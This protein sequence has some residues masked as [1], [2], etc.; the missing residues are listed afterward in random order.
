VKGKGNY[1]LDE[2]TWPIVRDIFDKSLSGWSLNKIALWLTQHGVPT[3]S[4]VLLQR[5]LR[6]P[7]KKAKVATEWKRQTVAD[8][9]SNPSYTGKHTV[10]RRKQVKMY[11]QEDS[12]EW[13]PVPNDTEPRKTMVLRDEGDTKRV[14]VDI[15]SIISEAEWAQ[16]QAA[17]MRRKEE[18]SRRNHQPEATLLRS[19]IAICGHCGRLMYVASAP[20]KSYT[21]YVCSGKRVAKDAKP[22]TYCPGGSFNLAAPLVDGPVWEAVMEI[23]QHKEK[24]KEILTRRQREEGDKLAEAQREDALTAAQI[25]SLTTQ[26]ANLRENLRLVKGEA[27]VLLAEDLEQVTGVLRQLEKKRNST[28]MRVNVLDAFINHLEET[29]QRW[30]ANGGQVRQDGDTL[31]LSHPDDETDPLHRRLEITLVKEDTLDNITYDEKR[32]LMRTLGIQVKMYASNSDFTR[33]TGRR[34]E[35]VGGPD[36]VSDSSYRYC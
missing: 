31:V 8:I 7:G 4:Q 16:A 18:A 22:G 14:V 30:V 21:E 11:Y 2:E 33:E 24:L 36:I 17:M 12:K 15:P 10:Y 6:N 32:E 23:A 9:V 3:P 25:E 13:T 20:R 29:L 1:L 28:S 34:W 19:G 27:A 26:Q 35:L 5:G